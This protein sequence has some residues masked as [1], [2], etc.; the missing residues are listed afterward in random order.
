MYAHNLVPRT[1]FIV[2]KTYPFNDP[3]TM[4]TVP[5]TNLNTLS[6][7]TP[8]YHP[9]SF[10]RDDKDPR[11]MNPLRGEHLKLDSKP[12]DGFVDSYH[13]Y[14]P[15]PNTTGFASYPDLAGGDLK[16]S[17]SYLLANPFHAPIFTQSHKVQGVIYKDPMDGIRPQY[18]FKHIVPYDKNNPLSHPGQH[19]SD[20]TEGNRFREELISR[21]SRRRNEERYNPLCIYDMEHNLRPHT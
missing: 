20:I 4:Y 21:Q 2:D 7:E 14:A 10:H 5:N 9:T 13:V 12:R 8:M 6:S 11:L 1:H 19:L 15:H 17:C 18:N 16:Y 3:S